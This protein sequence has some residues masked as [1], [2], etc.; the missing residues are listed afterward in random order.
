MY[1]V[2][3]FPGDRHYVLLDPNMEQLGTVI[4]KEDAE[5]LAS[6]LNRSPPPSDPLGRYRRTTHHRSR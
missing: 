5:H 1:S 3:R 6:F 2:T 4:S